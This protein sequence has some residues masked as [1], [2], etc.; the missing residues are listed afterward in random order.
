MKY[1]LVT[2]GERLVYWLEQRLFAEV[3]WNALSAQLAKYDWDQLDV[4]DP[5]KVR[6]AS[7]ELLNT[8]SPELWKCEWTMHISDAKAVRDKI[9]ESLT[10]ISRSIRA[11]KPWHEEIDLV[12]L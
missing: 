1:C 11:D 4:A 8:Q 6:E 12:A 10:K 7:V 9:A 5:E 2:D 3:R